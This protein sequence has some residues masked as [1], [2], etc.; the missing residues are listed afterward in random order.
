[1]RA[2]TTVINAAFVVERVIFD[3]DRVNPEKV[4][5]YMDSGTFLLA[6][7]A[8]GVVGCVYVEPR[9]QSGYLGLLSVAPERQGSGLGRQMVAA[10][11]DFARALRLNTMD[12]RVLSARSE[13]VPFYQRLGYIEVGTAPFA[14]GV[15]S[16]VPSHYILM[17]KPLVQLT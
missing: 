14:S 13:L 3:G 10:A 8:T 15:R 12:L 7:D 9:G 17:S 1:V 4:R 11:E 6:E 16:K 5:G 2:L